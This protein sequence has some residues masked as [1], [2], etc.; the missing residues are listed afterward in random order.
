MNGTIHLALR[1]LS[2]ARLRTL[3][4]ALAVALGVSLLVTMSVFRSGIEATWTAGENKFAFIVEITQ[5]VF[6]GMGLMT[7]GAAG[8][9]IYNAFAMSVARQRQQIGLLRAV[10]MRGGQVLRLVLV[11]VLITGGLGT[12][13]GVL[14]GPLVGNA[15]LSAM[16]HFGVE[17]MW[18]SVALGSAA[19]A[20]GMGVGISLLSALV[21]ARRAARLSPLEALHGEQDLVRRADLPRRQSGAG[22]ALPTGLAVVLLVSLWTYLA[23]AP[24]GTW[25]GYHQPWDVILAAL[26]LPVWWMGLVLLTPVLLGVATRSLRALLRRLP[27][28]MGRLLGDNLG[29]APERLHLTALTFAVALLM[30]VSTS[31]FVSFGNDVM[32][33]R[34]A[35]Q[36]LRERAWYVYPFNRVA[37]LAQLQ[38]F[39]ADAPAL[40]PVIVADVARLAAGRATVEPFY[41]VAV[42]EIASPFPGFPS[43]VTLHP[44]Q[45]TRPGRFSLLE[46]DWDTAL[47]LLQE[48]CGLLVSP[49]IAAR[50]GAGVGEAITVTGRTGPVTCT[51]AAI[52]AGGFAPMSFIGP[53]AWEQFVVPGQ[54][55]DSLQVRPLPGATDADVAALEADLRALSARYGAERV[56]VARPED[57]LQSITSTSDQLMQ[58]MNGLLFLV[59]GAGALGSVNTTLMSILERQRELVLL[60]ALGA[61]RRQIARLVVAESAV[62]ALLGALLGLLAGWGTIAIYALTYGGVTFGLVDLPLWT[63]VAEITW[64]AL[65]AGLPWLL[66]A[67]LLAGLTAYSVLRR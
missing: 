36:A 29:R 63:A 52:G 5:L 6:G 45:L 48:G 11:E 7:L 31:G 17:T 44:E 4:S 30:I 42:P 16:T 62:T 49:A 8:F 15:I 53:G 25:T 51:I 14:A 57:E 34:V 32:V 27:G 47:P 21:P 3:L 46:G 19:L 38:A 1:N 50:Y 2:R 24:P 9:L 59:V 35:A 28:G 61:T 23:A 10:G 56:F 13:L 55:P 65:R 39:Q 60:R 26:F 12:A 18:G 33:G 40:E 22:G 58:I 54:S 66:A 41:M 20:G 64:P 67:P 37:G 43:L